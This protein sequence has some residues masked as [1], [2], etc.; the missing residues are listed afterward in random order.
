MPT[1]IAAFRSVAA[2]VLIL[3]YIAVAA[4]IALFIG[5]VFRWKRGMYALGHVGAW[6]ALASAGIRYRVIGREHVPQAGAVVFCAN[7]E[8]NVDPPVLFEAL[9][10][11]LHILYKAE[12]HRFPVMGTVFDVGG[13]VPVDRGDRERALASIER[14]AASL[15]EGNSF[16]IFPEGTR[17]RTGEL[18]PFKK[19]GFI[20]AIRA[21]VPV[22]PVA[23]SGGRAAMRKGSP[24]VRPVHV[25]VR[26][27][28][29]IPTAGLGLEH[30]DELISRVRA[31]VQNLLQEGSVWT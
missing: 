1:L 4:P 10:P 15:R 14:G 6:L 5:V 9:H 18:L 31:E 24:I 21:Q 2:Y 11:Q 30:R 20:M 19:G 22:V 13:F 29:P 28:P 27:G 26:I 7:H 8:S 25:T 16:L 23:I 12:L 17:S 3:A